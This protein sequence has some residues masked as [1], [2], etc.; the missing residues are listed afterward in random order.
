M[1]IDLSRFFDEPNEFTEL[2]K[3]FSEC[4]TRSDFESAL[5]NLDY[6]L[7]NNVIPIQKP[8]SFKTSIDFISL[9][10]LKRTG[11]YDYDSI[12]LRS[13]ANGSCLFSSAS[14]AISGT[15]KHTD[16]LRFRTLVYMI[17]SFDLLEL[18][19]SEA[20]KASPTLIEAI[21]DC[22]KRYGW[23]SHFTLIGLC[24]VIGKSI[25]VLY[26]SIGN[27]LLP[28]IFTRVYKPF[29]DH[30][31]CRRKRSRRMAYVAWKGHLRE[32]NSPESET[33]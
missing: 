29:I 23:S 1:N 25:D 18:D 31:E 17:E 13:K 3:K 15:N 2:L 10:F 16:E 32:E 8:A 12:P 33:N 24:N 14:L 4:E 26:P 11:Q 19:Q 5:L 28:E 27:S 21:V 7:S 6:D 22:S 30:G 9:Y 20:R